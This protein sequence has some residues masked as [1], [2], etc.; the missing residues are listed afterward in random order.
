MPPSTRLELT[1]PQFVPLLDAL[2]ATM[3]LREFDLMLKLHLDIDRETI[4]AGGNSRQIYF[5][6]IDHFNKRSIV[7]KLVDACRKERPDNPVFVEYARIVGI[8][9][10]GLPSQPKLRSL[11]RQTNSTLD[12]AQYRAAIGRIE[13]RVC[14]V[15]RDGGGI[16]TGFLVGPRHVLT[17]CYVVQTI[18]DGQDAPA[19]FSCRFDFKMR[20]DGLSVSE[21]KSVGV[22]R[23]L[24]FSPLDPRE[25]EDAE[26]VPD[27]DN[28]DYAL[29]ELKE[30][31]GSLPILA[32]SD[33]AP[34]RGWFQLDLEA[35]DFVE[36]DPLFIVHHPQAGP[37]KVAL[38]MDSV[39]G[40]NANGTRVRYA[41]TSEAGSAGSPCFDVDWKL[42][43]LHHA[44]RPEWKE[45]IPIALI[46]RHLALR[47]PK[48]QRKALRL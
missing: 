20:D 43:A 17:N 14:R 28:L 35:H 34:K 25:F 3:S 8:G 23:L 9:P 13:G 10:R 19:I 30:K 40:L 21:G 45:G 42:V 2:L 15:D 12:P 36:H 11:V 41:A 37:M 6:V 5:E 32:E 1:G 44:R 27:P 38:N 47:L 29:L 18:L 31:V 33:S 46:A 24:A 39:I 22:N 48:T 16:A 4:A 26:A 7:W